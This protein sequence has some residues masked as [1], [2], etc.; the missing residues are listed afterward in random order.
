MDNKLERLLNQIG[1]TE[2]YMECFKD[3]SVDK[4][5]IDRESNSFNFII[6]MGSIPQI[7]VYDDVLECLRSIIY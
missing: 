6:K 7:S 3:S 4:V 2:D 1:I 5:V